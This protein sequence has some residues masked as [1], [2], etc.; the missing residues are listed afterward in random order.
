MMFEQQPRESNKAFAAFK[1][2]L[3]LGAER[4]LVRDLGAKVKSVVRAAY[5]RRSR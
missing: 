2:Y 1:T 5:G 3:E 4:S